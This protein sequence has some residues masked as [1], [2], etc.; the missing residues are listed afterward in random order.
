MHTK[1]KRVIC[2]GGGVGT[3]NLLRGLKKYPIHLGVVTSMADDGGS[4][5]RLRKAY[6]I[7]PPGDIISC[8]AALIPEDQKELTDLLTYRFTGPAKENTS[9]GDQKFGNLLMLAEIQRTKNFYRAI[10]VVKKMFS[11]TADIFPASDERTHLSATTKDGRRVHS[12][13][14]L[15]LALYSEPHG[16]KK[17]FIKPKEP[18]VNPQVILSL[19]N[20]DVIISGPGDLYTNQLPVLVIPQI[21]EALFKSKAKKIFILN[22]ANKPFETKGFTLDDF[23]N[24]FE[25]HL[26][27]F[28]FDLIIANNN[29]QTPIPK[30]YDY[31]Y[32]PLGDTLTRHTKAFKLIKSNLVNQAFPLYHDSKKLASEVVKH[33]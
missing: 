28:P 26:G 16:L 8:I 20:A 9:I 4:S 23:V 30:Q 33:I 32:I 14:T 2:L 5:G 7:M 12:E 24:A 21:K 25:E 18:K 3:S 17:I 10:D 1:Q 27:T 19:L 31:H 22:I 6:K 15:D 29:T 13:T 11:V